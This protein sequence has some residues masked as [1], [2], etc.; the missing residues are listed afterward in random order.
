MPVKLLAMK[1]SPAS[2]SNSQGSNSQDRIEIRNQ[3]AVALL[4]SLSSARNLGPFLGR[5][6][7]VSGAAAELKQDIKSVY[8]WTQRFKAC[9][10]LIETQPVPRSGRAIR[11]YRSAASE[12]MIPVAAL[13]LSILVGTDNLLHQQMQDALLRTWL[14][15]SADR[16]WGARVY[17]EGGRVSIDMSDGVSS[18]ER[19]SEAVTPAETRWFPLQLALPDAQAFAQELRDLEERYKA[20]Q[21]PD[22]TRYL[23]HLAVVEGA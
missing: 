8:R 1:D 4:L 2:S 12:F 7:T 13:P 14:K 21:T 11:H 10:L 18:Q 5:E 3:Q 9:G 15:N 20:R 17:L 22:E 19:I 23:V 6:N 16:P